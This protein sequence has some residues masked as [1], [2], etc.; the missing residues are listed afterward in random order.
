MSR[1][2]NITFG[3][4]NALYVARVL[5]SMVLNVMRHFAAEETTSHLLVVAFLA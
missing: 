1:S 3:R 4:E 5:L 2:S